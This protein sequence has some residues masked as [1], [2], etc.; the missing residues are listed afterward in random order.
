MELYLDT[1]IASIELSD[2]SFNTYH[3]RLYPINRYIARVRVAP[4]ENVIISY[5]SRDISFH[6]VIYQGR[7]NS[8]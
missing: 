6:H 4:R 8:N 7:S 2:H 5:Y 3:I 1:I